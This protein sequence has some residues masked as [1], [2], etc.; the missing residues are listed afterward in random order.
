MG[1]FPECYILVHAKTE[2]TSF[3]RFLSLE[4]M[5]KGLLIFLIQQEHVLRALI[6]TATCL[7]E[8]QAVP[9]L[10]VPEHDFFV[11]G[12]E[13]SGSLNSLWW[14]DLNICQT[15][16]VTNGIFQEWL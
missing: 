12:P 4:L 6:S 1:H 14:H 13:P 2:S 11:Y 8:L 7:I 10:L 9:L 3:V 16:F 5:Q 15:G